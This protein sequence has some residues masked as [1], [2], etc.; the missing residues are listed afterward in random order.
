MSHEAVEPVEPVEPAALG[1]P[2]MKR[3][4][5]RRLCPFRHAGTQAPSSAQ[6][7]P[8]WCR[9]RAG[10]RGSHC[11]G[12]GGGGDGGPTS[13][14]PS[15]SS[16]LGTLGLESRGQM[17]G[18]QV[19]AGPRGTSNSRESARMAWLDLPPSQ[20]ACR[21]NTTRKRP[22]QG[23]IWPCPGSAINNTT[24]PKALP[25]AIVTRPR[26]SQASRQMQ[27][28]QQP[29]RRAPHHPPTPRMLRALE[30]PGTANLLPPLVLPRP[31]MEPTAER[32]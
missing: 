22:I 14:S 27:R 30:A 2:V 23:P 4:P 8:W 5:S 28:V 24:N 7:R 16:T 9:G 1:R 12:G 19:E 21:A 31:C 25:P 17:G 20:P 13:S 3:R 26:S 18:G 15:L 11:G 32:A 29:Q 6:Q 10:G